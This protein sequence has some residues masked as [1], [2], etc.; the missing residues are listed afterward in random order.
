MRNV[1]GYLRSC[2]YNCSLVDL[3]FGFKDNKEGDCGGRLEEGTTEP[4]Y[5]KHYVKSVV[6]FQ[7]F[8]L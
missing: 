5:H 4:Q 2:S 7:A 1:L 6:D 8:Q 3:E